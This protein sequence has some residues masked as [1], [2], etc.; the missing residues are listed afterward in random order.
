MSKVLL[1]LILGV[2]L[3]LIDGLTSLF[4]PEVAPFI[5]SILI[6]STLKGMVAGIAI[7]F[8][9]RKVNSLPWGILFGFAV[10]FLVTV[11]FA[12]MPNPE[13]GSTYFWE[14]IIPGSLLGIIVGYSTQKYGVGKEDTRAY[15]SEQSSGS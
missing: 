10:A 8:F 6:G 9:A 14:I 2:I 13:T 1:G 12:I 5:E 7:G 3:G 11:P 4:T 15:S